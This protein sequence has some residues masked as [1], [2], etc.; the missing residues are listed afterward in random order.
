M[1]KLF[2]SVLISVFIFL[3]VSCGCTNDEI[4]LKIDGEKSLR[5]QLWGEVVINEIQ[6]PCTVYFGDS[7]GNKLQGYTKIGEREAGKSFVLNGTVIPP[8]ATSIVAESGEKSVFVKIPDSYLL[9]RD[10]AFVFGALS[11]IHYNKYKATG[12]DDALIAFDRALDYFDKIGVDMVGVTGDLS[13][14]GEESAL[15]KYNDAIKD[16]DYPVLTV[17]GNHD[18]PAYKDGSWKTHISDNIK[19]CTFAENGV[20]FVY[21]PEK[22]GGD[23]FVFLNITR[24]S[25]SEKTRRVIGSDQVK[26]LSGVLDAHRDD[27]VYLFFHLFMCGPDG[28]SHTGVGNIMNPGGYTYP[29]PFRYANPDERDF[30]KLMKEHKNV[31]YLSG[32]SHWM[33][34]ME[35]YGEQTNFSNFDDE[36][37]HMV[38]VPSVTEPRWIGE[39]DT[40]RTGKNGEASEGWVIY[41]YGSTTV[42][43]PM[44]FISGTVYTEYMEIIIK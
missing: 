23:V 24:W 37:C 25:Y 31:I 13:N 2:L 33:F 35:I 14:D 15:I 12:E 20:D 39:N 21:E 10:D 40:E 22:T 5:G 28:Q 36:Y 32:H 17:T 42:L 11:D 1:K 41:D 6:E 34:E 9:S 8:D 19:N 30:R 27:Q 3:L 29:L 26:W 16:R 7:E 4:E 38:H 43:V 44:D 18:H